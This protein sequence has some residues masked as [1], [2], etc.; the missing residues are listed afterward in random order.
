MRPRRRF[1]VVSSLVVLVLAIPGSA[2]AGGWWTYLHEARSHVVAGE[3]LRVSTAALFA[4]SEEAAREVAEPYFVYLVVGFDADPA[5]DYGRG[6]QPYDWVDL[7]S[8]SR[9]RIGEITFGE[10]DSNLVPIRATV[11]IPTTL[12]PGT[13]SLLACDLGC[14]RPLA[15]VFPTHV[16]VWADADSAKVANQLDESRELLYQLR[17]DLRQERAKANRAERTV[18][19]LEGEIQALE[20]QVANLEAQLA[21]MAAVLSTPAQVPEQDAG[22]LRWW[23]MAMWF[24]IGV[25]VGGAVAMLIVRR[26]R[27]TAE[28]PVEAWREADR[29]MRGG[30]D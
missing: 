26:R 7:G 2:S 22:G 3:N 8:L 13:Y 24:L 29:A 5:I 30:I 1:F 16:R 21:D 12:A 14:E 27:R 6:E 19:R 25:A 9:Y 11:T 20:G 18:T 28:P 23:T 15:N 4:S 10:A 17:T